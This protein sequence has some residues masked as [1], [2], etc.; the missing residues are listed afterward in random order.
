MSILV[1]MGRADVGS[2]VSVCHRTNCVP[3]IMVTQ[4]IKAQCG[5]LFQAMMQTTSA[6]APTGQGTLVT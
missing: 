5:A 4:L 2:L 3:Q 6:A 1:P